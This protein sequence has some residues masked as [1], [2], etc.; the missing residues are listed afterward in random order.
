[1]IENN[2]SFIK[3][4]SLLLLL[5]V[6]MNDC[7]KSP[8]DPPAILTGSLK[9]TAMIDTILVDSMEVILDN[10]YLGIYQNL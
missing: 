2:V 10:S 8:S 9:I 1:M 4:L 3:Y 5:V 7:G 6:L